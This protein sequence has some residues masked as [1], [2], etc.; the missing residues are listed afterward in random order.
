ML[1]LTLPAFEYHHKKKDKKE[2]PATQ[3]KIKCFTHSVIGPDD[4]MALQLLATSVVNNTN[5]LEVVLHV[6][7]R[8]QQHL[9]PICVI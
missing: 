6:S 5:R 1:V 4:H 8:C 7:Q 9:L 2:Q 3:F